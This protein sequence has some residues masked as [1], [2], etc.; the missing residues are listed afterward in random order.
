MGEPALAQGLFLYAP[1]FPLSIMLIE[2]DFCFVNPNN[3]V[4]ELYWFPFV[5]FCEGFVLLWWIL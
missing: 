5:C 2:L 1:H 3:A 4:P